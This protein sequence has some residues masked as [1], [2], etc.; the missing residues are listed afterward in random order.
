[1]SLDKYKIQDLIEE[2][3]KIKVLLIL[4]SPYI[5]EYIHN[6]P[7]AGSAGKKLTKLFK[8]NGYLSNFNSELPLGCNIKNQK[9]IHLG[10]MNCSILPMDNTFY[11]CIL[12]DENLKIKDDLMSIKKRLEKKVQKKYQTKSEFELSVFN[13]FSMRLNNIIQNSECL[14]IIP[15][16]NIA[17][18]FVNLFEKENNDFIILDYLPHPTAHN[19]YKK[20]HELSIWNKIPKEFLP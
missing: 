9:Y 6:H 4:E 12:S 1:M 16:G 18:N 8:D 19:W 2:P 14:I 7:A 3:S 17:K 5:N 11:P 15:C 13:D 10:I 20:T